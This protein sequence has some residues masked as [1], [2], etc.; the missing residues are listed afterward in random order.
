M[1]LWHVEGDDEK[2]WILYFDGSKY[3]K[4]VGVSILL[5]Y[6]KGGIIIMDYKFIFKCTNIMVEY[7]ALVIMGLKIAINLDLDNL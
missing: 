2:K 4:G 7:E 5:L 3:L 6:P 1:N